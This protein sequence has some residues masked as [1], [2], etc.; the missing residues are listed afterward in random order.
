MNAE[1]PA[2]LIADNDA[3]FR[4]TVR[5]VLLP[6][7]Y[8]IIEAEDGLEA[9]EIV[10]SERVHVLLLDMHMPRRTGLETL[11]WVKQFKGLL[12]CV[13]LSARMDDQLRIEAEKARAFDVL[14]KPVSRVDLTGVV[15]R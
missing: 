13:L 7:G 8:Q 9:I 4:S 1:Q 3:Q 6:S 14:R 10:R 12:P 2:I 5:E 15:E 11:Q